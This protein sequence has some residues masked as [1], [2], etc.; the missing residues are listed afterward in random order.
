MGKRE[1]AKHF[2][3]AITPFPVTFCT[4]NYGTERAKFKHY[5]G[6]HLEILNENLQRIQSKQSVPLLIYELDVSHK[7]EEISHTHQPD[8]HDVNSSRYLTFKT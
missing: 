3:V 5:R 8:E 7:T 2:Q 1:I 4:T 6:R